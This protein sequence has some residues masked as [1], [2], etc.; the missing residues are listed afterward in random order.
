MLTVGPCLGHLTAVFHLGGIL[1]TVEIC[2]WHFRSTLSFWRQPLITVLVE[3]KKSERNSQEGKKL[4]TVFKQWDACWS[5]TVDSSLLGFVSRRNLTYFVMLSHFHLSSRP[6]E[7]SVFFCC[8]T[9]D[10][11][12]ETACND[13]IILPPCLFIHVLGKFIY[14][15]FVFLCRFLVGVFPRWTDAILSGLNK[16]LLFCKTEKKREIYI[17]HNNERLLFLY[18]KVSKYSDVEWLFHL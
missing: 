18:F 11:I 9:S 12:T 2:S 4:T 16:V 10:T 3:K 14:F 7:Y 15:Y 8:H 5:W 17:V 6:I 13:K 1:W